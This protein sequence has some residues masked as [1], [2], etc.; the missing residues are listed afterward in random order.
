VIADATQGGVLGARV[1][2]ILL[3]P[4]PSTRTSPDISVVWIWRRCLWP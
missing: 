1:L 2:S 4:H 3:L